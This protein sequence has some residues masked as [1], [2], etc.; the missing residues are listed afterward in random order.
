MS[1]RAFRPGKETGYDAAPKNGLTELPPADDTG[2][3][4]TPWRKAINRVLTGLA[5][6]TFT[7]NL[8]GLN[9]LLPGIGIV[10]LLLGFRALRRENQWFHICW[11]ISV[12]RTVYFWSLLILNATIWRR[13]VSQLSFFTA[14]PY[15]NLA[16]ISALIFCLRGGFSAVQQKAGRPVHT[17][18]VSALRSYCPIAVSGDCRLEAI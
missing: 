18:A 13:L 6:S 4:A 8:L 9:Y 5:L 2:G 11:I 14:L 16:V 1:D 17:A 15:V 3:K 7:L 12:L 10:L